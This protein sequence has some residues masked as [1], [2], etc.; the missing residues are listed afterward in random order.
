[1]TDASDSS[2]H[3]KPNDDASHAI[4]PHRLRGSSQN[5]NSCLLRKTDWLP[6]WANLEEEDNHDPCQP[7]NS[8]DYC[9]G[10][11]VIL[12]DLICGPC[13]SF[14][15]LDLRGPRKIVGSAIAIAGTDGIPSQKERIA[16]L[17]NGLVLPGL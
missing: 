15:F 11:I 16:L 5:F 12:R 13:R 10:R 9:E 2:S 14:L 8:L 17:G 4:F 6:R 7:W 1:V 3:G